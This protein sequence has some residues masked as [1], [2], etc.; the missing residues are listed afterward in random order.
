MRVSDCVCVRVW[1]RDRRRER[2]KWDEKMNVRKGWMR[3]MD[4][5][6]CLCTSFKLLTEPCA[7]PCKLQCHLI[8]LSVFLSG[9]LLCRE[10][11]ETCPTEDVQQRAGR[12]ERWERGG[13]M[14]MKA[15]YVHVS[16]D[17][18]WWITIGHLVLRVVS[19]HT[20]R[21]SV[22]RNTA[23]EELSFLSLCCV[24]HFFH[25]YHILLK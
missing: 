1:N 13:C 9:F 15:N 8:T 4:D 21:N 17:C 7:R 19:K 20:S 10:N 25:P 5:S 11:R 14:E 2:E 24:Q 18:L 12:A 16:D 3:G 23:A 22:S 6:G